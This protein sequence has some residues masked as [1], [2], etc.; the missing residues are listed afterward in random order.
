M[1]RDGGDLPAHMPALECVTRQLRAQ[2]FATAGFS[3]ADVLPLSKVHVALLSLATLRRLLLRADNTPSAAQLALAN[4]LYARGTITQA[5]E[6]ARAA[7]WTG[8]AAVMPPVV[9]PATVQFGMTVAAGL[10]QQAAICARALSTASFS[11][12]TR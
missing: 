6:L 7:A 1:L 11:A 2:G 8:S 12:A 10:L 4:E 9:V 3:N 5:R